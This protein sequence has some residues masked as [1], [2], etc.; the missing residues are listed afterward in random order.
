[1]YLTVIKRIAQFNLMFP[2]NGSKGGGRTEIEL[3][4]SRLCSSYANLTFCSDDI[5]LMPCKL[6]GNT[7]KQSSGNMTCSSIHLWPSGVEGV[8]GE[9]DLSMRYFV[10]ILLVKCL[11]WCAVTCTNCRFL[12]ISFTY[13]AVYRPLAHIVRRVLLSFERCL[14]PQCSSCEMYGGQ[15]VRLASILFPLSIVLILRN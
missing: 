15:S 6:S 14:H 7:L 12:S 8:G 13:H 10:R 11:T 5:T 2:G 1:M 3:M 9:N 4:A